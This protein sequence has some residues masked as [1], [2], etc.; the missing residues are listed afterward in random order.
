MPLTHR[1]RLEDLAQL[2][3]R[4]LPQR[5]QGPRRLEQ[6]GQCDVGAVGRSEVVPHIV[7]RQPARRAPDSFKGTRILRTLC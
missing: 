3:D 5:P 1:R 2:F 7:R 6:R 4:G